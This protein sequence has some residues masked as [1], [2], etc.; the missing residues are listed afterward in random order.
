MTPS[1]LLTRVRSQFDEDTAAFLSDANDIY[2]YMSDAEMELANDIGCTQGVD[3]NTSTVAGTQEY[4]RPSDC[5]RIEVL[6]WNGVK[7]KKI[8]LQEYETISGAYYG[9]TTTQGNPVYYYEWADVVGLYPI[10]DTV[11]TLSYYYVKRPAAVT[12]SS[13]A[14]TVTEE[15]H[16]AIVD[17]CL[18]RAYLKDQDGRAE[19]HQQRWEER[20]KKLKADFDLR[21]YRDQIV[22]VRDKNTLNTT[23]FGLI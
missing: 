15:F 2:P 5:L 8:D 22:V 14:F 7:L 19:I 4:T 23:D 12:A 18:F 6:R 20:K 13:A 11:Q 16:S 3:A 9:A 17:Y 1:Q 21:K 10:P